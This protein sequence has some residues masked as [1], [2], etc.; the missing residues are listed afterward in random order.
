M[1]GRCQCVP[2]RE[3]RGVGGIREIAGR[4]GDS[5]VIATP[6]AV[7]PSA[8][9]L[10]DLTK[11]TCGLE[12]SAVAI[13]VNNSVP[14]CAP[15][16]S[17]WPATAAS[18]RLCRRAAI[19]RPAVRGMSNDMQNGGGAKACAG[20]ACRVPTRS[21]FAARRLTLQRYN[22]VQRY[23][24]SKGAVLHPFRWRPRLASVLLTSRCSIRGLA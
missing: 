9:P 11:T 8:P 17:A 15:K 20:L 16:T 13:I 2:G 14:L 10:T 23:V 5:H 12:A 18:R 22:L 6:R 3:S 21:P 1:R 7:K 4:R 24:F 19:N